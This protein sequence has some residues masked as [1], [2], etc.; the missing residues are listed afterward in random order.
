MSEDREHVRE[1]TNIRKQRLNVL[2]RQKA[3]YGLGCPPHILIEIEELRQE[4]TQL[5]SQIEDR[6]S[7]IDL[8]Q[9]KMRRLRNLELQAAHFGIT[10][11]PEILMEIED[12]HR[13]I[14]E[15]QGSVPLSDIPNRRSTIRSQDTSVERNQ[16]FVSYS[17]KDTR[18]LQRLQVHLKPLERLGKITLWND[19]LIDPGKKWREEIRKAIDTTKVA[20]LLISADFLASDFIADNE[21]PPLLAS[22]ESNGAVILPVIVSSCRFGQAE[23]LSQFQAVNLPSQPIN[24]MSKGRQEAIFVKVSEAVE[25][26][27]Q[28]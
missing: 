28:L 24:M 27:F 10:A 3:V 11:P 18:W 15:L 2:L 13:D 9:I 25:K 16:V 6:D 7:T 5:N 23:T 4:V 8:I 19:T 20:I 21:I 1:L 22:A 12:L 26:A 17:H 14:D